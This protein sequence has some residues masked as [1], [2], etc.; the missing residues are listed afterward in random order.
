[1]EFNSAFKGL[2]SIDIS[3]HIQGALPFVLNI[4]TSKNNSELDKT[5]VQESTHTKTGYLNGAPTTYEMY[6]N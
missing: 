4:H 6:G 1:M 3:S 5:Q 2:N